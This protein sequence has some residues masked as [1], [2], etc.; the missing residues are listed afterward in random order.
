MPAV[1]THKSIMLLA[2]ERVKQFQ[3]VLKRKVDR[4]VGVTRLDRQLL[5]IATETARVF[6][7]E[8]RPRTQLP[9]I[10]FAE[11]VG[12]DNNRYPISQY[13]VLGSMGPDLTAFS[14]I[15]APGQDWVFD[16]IHKGTPDPDR[17]LV[18]AQTCDFIMQ[19][20]AK[21]KQRINTDMA[22]G[23][24]R[25]A[26]LDKMRAYTLGHLCHIAA[27]VISH[28]YV[29]DYQWQDPPKDVKKFHAA[30]EGEMDALVARQVLRRKSTRSGQDWDV[31]WPS[32]QPPTQFYAAYADALESV[33]TAQ[34]RRRTGYGEFEKHLNDL[35]AEA[36]DAEFV[37]DGYN[38]LRHGIVGKYY[39]FGYGSWFKWLSL[40][41]V[42]MLALPI[43]LLALPKASTVILSDEDKRS[44]R[45]WMEFV[46]FP[47]LFALPA[48][49]GYGWL[50]GSLT[51]GGVS[52]RY[53]LGMVGAIISA[54]SGVLLLATLKRDTVRPGF[55]WPVLF[56]IPAVFSTLQ[57]FMALVE[58]LRGDRIP[59]A[60]LSA[61]YALPIIF[62]LLM[63]LLFATFPRHSDATSAFKNTGFWVVFILWALAVFVGWFLLPC[64]IRDAKIPETPEDNIVKRR[65]VQVF[66]EG[67]LHHDNQLEAR[68]VP[69]QVY[70]SGRRKL[71]K[72]WW[73][74]AGDLYIR[75][76][77]YQLAF[78]AKE[79]GS[80]AQ[81]VAAPIAPMTL[82]EYMNYLSETVVQP[83]T[84]VKN[85][86]K[87]S[88][89]YPADTDYELPA[90]AVFADHGD[91]KTGRVDHDRKAAKFEQLGTSA[92]D[93]DYHLYHAF[94]AEQAVR[95]GHKGAVAPERNLGATNPISNRVEE[96][97]YHY[98]HAPE[99]AETTE[100][101]M[102]Y[103]GDFGAILSMAA[104]TH[105]TTNLRDSQSKK[106]DKVYQVFR[107]W[108]LDRRRVN[109]WRTLVAGG[110]LSEKGSSR[111][112]YDNNMLGG[113]LRP[114]NHE[115][116]QEA[117]RHSSQAAF[118]EGEKTS[119]ELGW[120]NVVREWM[121]VSATPGQNTLGLTSKKPGNPSNLA[122]SRAMAYLFDLTDPA[123]PR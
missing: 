32:E 51:T 108:N 14:H 36:V 68:A 45:G 44:E 23:A 73:Q 8:P 10:M 60:A 59:R 89:V 117:L 122:L 64:I 20:W 80:D 99:S 95:Y 81:I 7:S 101:L 24:A 39:S 88:V 33:Y 119:R 29:N 75:S 6:S 4:G 41:A 84:N 38:V 118:E 90:G 28:P 79:N 37:K 121:D 70:P 93:S 63:L 13:A 76:D 40:L 22:A 100:T 116:W 55:S 34:S 49:I 109:E 18:N 58:F 69:A 9:G 83:G 86:L 2:R 61:I 107:N 16:G 96:E 48:T 53:W 106:V 91:T 31:W 26:Q 43:V 123:A 3:S 50:V 47:M 19:F 56:A 27:D 11:P 46:S 15:L 65:Y 77:R 97:G 120:V 87:W 114:D 42:P 111:S 62:T 74:G 71:V 30:I 113:T 78:S 102:S 82:T 85:Q 103:A 12:A 57:L 112:G 72:L 115:S 21:A 110:A 104:I 5:A 67:S 1:L 17:E 94:K 92:D 66:D 98:L 52:K 25:E 54:V 35:G 105:M